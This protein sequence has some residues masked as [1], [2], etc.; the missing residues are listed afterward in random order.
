MF[1]PFSISLPVTKFKFRTNA[2]R[3]LALGPAGGG[4]GFPSRSWPRN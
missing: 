3:V 2:Y 4:H 1:R